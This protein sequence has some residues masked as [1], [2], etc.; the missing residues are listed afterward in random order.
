LRAVVFF[1]A[2]FRFGADLFLAAVFF[3]ADFFFVPDFLAED[4][5]DDVVLEELRELERDEDRVRAGMAPTVS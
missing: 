5:R 3:A 4:E 1:A 2:V